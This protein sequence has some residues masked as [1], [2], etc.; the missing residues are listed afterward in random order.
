M[1]T[2]KRTMVSPRSCSSMSVLLTLLW[3]S[4]L[5]GDTSRV[6]RLLKCCNQ[7]AIAPSIIELKM[8]LGAA[9]T[10]KDVPNTWFFIITISDRVC[11]HVL[12]V[13]RLV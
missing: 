1:F 7:S 3:Y 4:N 12:M 5:G 11:I 10:T 8:T 13:F 9:N 2:S 6:I